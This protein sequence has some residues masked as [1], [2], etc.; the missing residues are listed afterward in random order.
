MRPQ[1]PEEPRIGMKL[2]WKSKCGRYRIWNGDSIQ[3]LKRMESKDATK[4]RKMIKAVITDPP[5]GINYNRED[6][7]QDKHH[8]VRRGRQTDSV[9]GDDAPFDPTPWLQF[10]R[11]VLWG[12]DNYADKLP[13]LAGRK[14]AWICWDK[15]TRN[16]LNLRI[17]EFELG[18]ARPLGR[19]QMLRL[20]W[21]GCSRQMER[22]KAFHPAQ[23]PVALMK[24][25]IERVKVPES[26]IVLDP[27][28]GSGPTGVACAQTG[29]PFWGVEIQE[30]Y[31]R[32][33]AER[34][35]SELLYPGF[36]YE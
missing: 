29:H 14:A 2:Y 4:M 12:A 25:C 11:I 17:A 15:I 10:N 35:E 36:R 6:S 16:G 27:Y 22:G 7:P 1:I 18:W 21:S 3:F 26:G 24:W 28:M 5:Y 9:E 19:N 33:A 34:I 23:K 31:C 30:K 32:I 8:P 13:D 20:M